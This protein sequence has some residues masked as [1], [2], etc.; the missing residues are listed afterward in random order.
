MRNFFPVRFRSARSKCSRICFAILLIFQVS[1]FAASAQTNIGTDPQVAPIT[2]PPETKIQLAVTRPIWA[3]AASVGDQIYALTAFPVAINGEMALPAGTYAQGVIDGFTRPTWRSPHAEFQ[4]HFTK[5]VFANGYVVELLDG[6][7]TSAAYVQVSVSNDVLLDNGSPLEMVLH[8]PLSLDAKNIA[9]AI[10]VSKPPQFSQ[11]K[12]ATRCVP[13]PG[14]SGTSDTV[15]PGTSPTVIPGGPGMPDT[16]IPGTSPTIISGTPGTPGTS[17]AAPPIVSD[18]P[19]PQGIHRESFRVTRPFSIA[20][21]QLA[22]GSYQVEWVGPGPTASVDILQNG[23]VVT[24]VQARVVTL[25]KKSPNSQVNVQAGANGT[26]ELI[27]I[28]FKRNTLELFF[29]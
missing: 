23:A 13:T 24:R 15:I 6:S 5:L 20:G 11:F 28:Q 14:T 26:D 12:S 16:V 27:S 18:K 2:I 29:N 10:R 8:N 17:C 1:A 22:A 3:R 21:Q 7:A 4:I 19:F 9:A 25:D